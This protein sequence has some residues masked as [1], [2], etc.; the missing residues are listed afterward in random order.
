MRL[1]L[2][3]WRC[4]LRKDEY[5]T[6]RMSSLMTLVMSQDSDEDGRD[7]KEGGGGRMVLLLL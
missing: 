4:L 6:G 5:D 3:C 1:V 7:K 2:L